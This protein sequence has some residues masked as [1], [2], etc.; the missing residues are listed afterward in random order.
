MKTIRVMLV[1]DNKEYREG[2]GLVLKHSRG[3]D[4]ISEFATSEVALRS[5][6]ANSPSMPDLVL[7]DLRLPGMDGLESMPYFQSY[8]PDTKIIIL[9]QSDSEEDV[10]RAIKRGAH[11]QILLD[12][13]LTHCLIDL[14]LTVS[15]GCFPYRGRFGPQVTRS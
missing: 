3:I 7:L 11:L 9:T 15:C 14:V 4:L 13:Q 5:L 8:A 1:E 10:L 2:I 6:Q 12:H